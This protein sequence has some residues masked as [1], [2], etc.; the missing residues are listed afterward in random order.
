MVNASSEQGML[1]VNG[2]SYQARDSKCKQCTDRNGHTRDFPEEG[3]LGGISF[4]RELEKRAWEIERKNSGSVIW[5][6]QV[7]LQKSSAFGEI[8]PQMKGAHVFARCTL[9]PAERNR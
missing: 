8:E 9:N 6:L 7:T 4:Q 5:R 1:A 3:P 2:M